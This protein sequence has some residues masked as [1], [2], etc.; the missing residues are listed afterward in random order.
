V[1]YLEQPA[2]LFVL[3]TPQEALARYEEFGNALAK[4]GLLKGYTAEEFRSHIQELYEKTARIHQLQVSAHH[5]N[6]TVEADIV[7][8]PSPR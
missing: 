2:N 1:N 3:I 4:D 5:H 6:G 8:N 7:L